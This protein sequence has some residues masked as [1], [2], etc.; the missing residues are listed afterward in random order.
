V[1]ANTPSIVTV[2]SVDNSVRALLPPV[3]AIAE[4]LFGERLLAK[5]DPIAPLQVVS[6]TVDNATQV[7]VALTQNL[8]SGMTLGAPSIVVRR[9]DAPTWADVTLNTTITT[10]SATATDPSKLVLKPPALPAGDTRTQVTYQVFLAGE[11]AA[12]LLS[13][14]NAPLAGMI[15]DPLTHPQRGRDVS[16]IGTGPST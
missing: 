16:I 11:T 14:K 13:D 9:L 5:E 2:V 12:P 4:A 8:L 7:T 10:T 15:G 1:S 6:C 3:Q